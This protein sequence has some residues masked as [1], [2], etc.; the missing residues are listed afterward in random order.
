MHS[1]RS[2]GAYCVIGTLALLCSCDDDP[3][4]PAGGESS[5]FSLQDVYVLYDP[6]G[7]PREFETDARVLAV[8][9][10]DETTDDEIE[11]TLR[12]FDLQLA[13]RAYRTGFGLTLIETD[14]AFAAARMLWTHRGLLVDY[15]G[16]VY[17]YSSCEWAIQGNEIIVKG[18]FEN[19]EVSSLLDDAG[20][21]FVDTIYG[22]PARV[23]ELPW[24]DPQKMYDLCNALT[25]HAAVEY[26]EPNHL[27]FLCLP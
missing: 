15:V 6:D 18:D 24:D 25:L 9:F 26:A 16:P 13:T 27:R 5:S 11:R 7:Q 3:T 1:M 10:P 14:D 17:I 21:K 22:D 8:R 20:A 19:A 2:A 4:Q 12:G 23:F